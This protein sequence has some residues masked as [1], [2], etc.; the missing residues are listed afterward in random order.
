MLLSDNPRYLKEI[1]TKEQ[2]FMPLNDNSRYLKRA[3]TKEQLLYT[4]IWSREVATYRWN[5]SFEIVNGEIKKEL[6]GVQ[7]WFL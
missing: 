1:R 5:Q 3:K 2:S 4:N 6:E 7:F